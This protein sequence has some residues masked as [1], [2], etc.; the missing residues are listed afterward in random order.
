MIIGEKKPTF[1]QEEANTFASQNALNGVNTHSRCV[2]GRYEKRDDMPECSLPG[3]D[4]GKLL[5]AFATLENL[6]I[7]VDE[8][9]AKK[10]LSA[11]LG[12]IGGASNFHFHTDDHNTGEVALG[13]G[14]IKYARQNPLEYGITIEIADL[15]K[16]SLEE[17]KGQGANEEVLSG[18]HEERAILVVKGEKGVAPKDGEGNQV[19]VYQK[20]MAEKAISDFAKVLVELDELKEKNITIEQLITTMNSITGKQ[21]GAT[22][23]HIAKDLPVYS[24]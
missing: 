23:G 3:A 11:L 21:L 24:V 5:I 20:T 1:T 16:R 8:Q 22:I 18:K 15:L 17:L 2:D 7:K 14:H 13:C 4:A 10:V 12:A 6:G 9:T 19:F